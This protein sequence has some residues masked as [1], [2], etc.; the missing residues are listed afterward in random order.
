VGWLKRYR[1]AFG[2]CP[3][4]TGAYENVARAMITSQIATAA[5]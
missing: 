4:H 1:K 5:A 3:H 2:T